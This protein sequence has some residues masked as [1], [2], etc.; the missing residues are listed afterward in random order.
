MKIR[1][2]LSLWLISILFPRIYA[3]YPVGEDSLDVVVITANRYEV[4]A[5][6]VAEMISTYSLR[7]QRE[8]APRSMAEAL[9]GVPGVWMQK[10]NHGGGS[11]F[12][13]GLTGNQT[14][15]LVD[16]IRL[17]N[18][19]FRYGPN[20]YLNT[21]DPLSLHR[22]E[23]L[24]G[25]ASVEYGTDALG[26]AVNLLSKTP[27]FSRQGEGTVFSWELIGKVFNRRWLHGSHGVEWP[28]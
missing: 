10:T 22:V 13:R 25:S 16:G 11:P 3:Q 2:F 21:I 9:I 19:T 12:I 15:V 26:G 17:N 24:R 28:C 5:L 4:Q 8:L 6:D 1:I 18:A 27:Q 14:L 23:V 20:Q 7:D